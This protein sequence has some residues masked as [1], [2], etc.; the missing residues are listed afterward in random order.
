MQEEIEKLERE[1]KELRAE[2]LNIRNI[3]QVAQ[4][5]IDELL[6]EN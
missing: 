1:N 2:L 6:T 3:L 4:Q 5:R